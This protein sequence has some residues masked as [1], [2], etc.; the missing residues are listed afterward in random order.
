MH[1][2]LLIAAADVPALRQG[3][4]RYPLLEKSYA[5]LRKT[6]DKALASPIVVPVP[7]D[8]AGG[9]THEQH[10]R[11]YYAMQAA[12]IS[13]QMTR[14]V[15]Y[16]RF[17]RDMLLEYSKL[18]PTLKN[19]PEAK[20]SSPG[21]LFHQALN[22]CNWVVYSIQG[23][24]AVYETLTPA[25]RTKIEN[26]AFRPLCNFFTQD[27]KPWFDLVH[28]H[29]VWAAAA[30]GMTGYALHDDK[31]INLALHGSAGTD[32]SGFLA[33]LNGLFSPEGYY[34]E[35]PYYSRYALSPFFMFA[36][37]IDNNQPALKIFQYR[38]KILQK[39]LNSS[40]QL[41]NNDG[42]Y[43][44]LND[45]LK[46]KDWTTQ[47]LVGAI[48]IAAEHY[49][50]DPTMLGV[51]QL[52]KK[53]LVSAG[54]LEVAKAL[55][56]AGKNL[57]EFQRVSQ[58]YRDG[59]TG[60]EGGLAV[61][62]TGPQT[63]QTSLL[64]KYTAHGLSHGHYDKLGIVLYDKGRE[65][66]QDYG[67]V[68]FLNVEAK[69]GGRYLPETHSFA[70]Q[71]V[72]HNTLV[73]DEASN[74]GGRE[75]EAEEHSGKAWFA[76]IANARV[77]VA[78]A[79][80]DDAY[81]GV[82]MQRTVALFTDSLSQKPLVLDVLRAQSATEHQYDLPFYYQGQLISTSFAYDRPANQQPLGPKNGYQHLWREAVGKPVRTPGVATLTW[83]SGPQFYS[84]TTATDTATHLVM[85]RIGA[86]DP[87]FNLRPEPVLLVRE[88]AKNQVF[89][90][91]IEAHG[92]FNPT[93]ETAAGSH[94]NVRSVAV[95]YDGAD[96]TVV[97][98]QLA[99]GG[100]YR[101][102]I[103][104]QDAAPGASHEVRVAGQP[105]RWQGPYVFRHF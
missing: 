88:K 74:F 75:K 95:L 85:A 87:K 72:A 21:R 42:R 54:G 5:A 32:K 24:D 33:Q 23:Y 4:T 71:T 61:L 27:L 45:A 80:A 17:V 47:E 67:A 96:A 64:F 12:G 98:V 100:T 70:S 82:A 7:K 73:V 83:L 99:R 14:D 93:A 35:G 53:V 69:E 25:E 84:M 94:S 11:N 65:V 39:A 55:Q 66:L 89:A 34:T 36:Q 49:G 50:V 20:S 52:Q 90:S 81:P 68:R 43:Y 92:E 59:A 78:S 56:A 30:V 9:Y 29:G 10:T 41:T 44:P 105:L 58:V 37:A 2:A 77:Q 79:K 6:A 40:L 46:E 62:R 15:K 22:D 1:P 28:N 26:G 16:A 31:L 63:D 101:L 18:I 8:P 13:Y 38:D 76:S 57:P 102:A 103:A 91:V 51:V 97:E 48:S 3:L 60:A 86:N 104:N 19:H